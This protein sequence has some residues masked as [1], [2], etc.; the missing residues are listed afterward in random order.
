MTP[1]KEPCK[2]KL[3]NALKEVQ[4]ISGKARM[5]KNRYETQC[6]WTIISIIGNVILA[7]IAFL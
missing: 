1:K 5:W 3:A 2:L 4:T 7:L 6:Y